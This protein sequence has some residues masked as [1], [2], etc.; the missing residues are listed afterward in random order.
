M[1]KPGRYRE[2]QKTKMSIGMWTMKAKFTKFEMGT[3][4]LLRI[5]GEAINVTV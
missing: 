4:T 3:R 1:G 2:V 5:R